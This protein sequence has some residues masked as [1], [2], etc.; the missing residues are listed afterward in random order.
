MTKRH[1][2]TVEEQ[3]RGVRKAIASPRTPKQLRSALKSRL[4]K[5]ETELEKQRD[6]GS[7]GRQQPKKGLLARLS[8]R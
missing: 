1:V 6:R 5:L 2:L 8:G 3:I 7:P 4:L